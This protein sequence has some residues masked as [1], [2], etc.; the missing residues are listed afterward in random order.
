MTFARLAKLCLFWLCFTKN[1][2]KL[3][4]KYLESDETNK[5]SCMIFLLSQQKQ[6]FTKERSCI[7]VVILKQFSNLSQCLHPVLLSVKRRIFCQLFAESRFPILIQINTK[8]VFLRQIRFIH[9]RF[10]LLWCIY[11]FE[12]RQHCGIQILYYHYTIP[13][14]ILYYTV[15]YISQLYHVAYTRYDFV[16]NFTVL[17]NSYFGHTIYSLI[18]TREEGLHQTSCYLK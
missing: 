9:L 6:H 16:L 14:Y 8:V 1:L 11:I 12:K 18:L 4:S 2:T 17:E 3:L 7:C 15:L 5:I 13:Y 10:M